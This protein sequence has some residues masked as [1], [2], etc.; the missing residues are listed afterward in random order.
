MIYLVD[1]DWLADV[2]AGRQ[3]AIDLITAL[4]PHGVGISTVTSMEVV[5][6]VH[7][8]RNRHRLEAGFHQFLEAAAIIDVS[9]AIADRAAD[10][11]L[12]LRRQKRQ[13]NERALDI[14]IAATALE[15]DLLLATRN[16]RHFADIPGLRL[17]EQE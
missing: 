13:V 17:H 16:R 11:R 5:E 2:L 4:L 15:L 6:G 12:D 10:I 9:R 1:S 8:S 3:P 14:L 7:G